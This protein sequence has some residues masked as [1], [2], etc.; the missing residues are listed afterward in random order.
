MA[1]SASATIESTGG[2]NIK[3][4]DPNDPSKMIDDSATVSAILLGCVAAYLLVIIIFGLEPKQGRDFAASDELEPSTAKDEEDI[5][6]VDF[7][8][9]KSDTQSAVED[10][11]KVSYNTT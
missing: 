9:S 3:T 1:S 10:S 4:Q 2:S 5:I 7:A 6:H 8:R 11:E